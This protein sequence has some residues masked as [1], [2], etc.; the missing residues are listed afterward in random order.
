MLASYKQS[1]L[2]VQHL[3]LKYDN[4]SFFYNFLTFMHQLEI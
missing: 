3:K 4:M 1:K 2:L